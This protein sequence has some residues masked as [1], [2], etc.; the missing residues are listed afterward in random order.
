MG[1]TIYGSLEVQ[2]SCYLDN[3]MHTE[4]GTER[5]VRTRTIS[6][7]TPLRSRGKVYEGCISGTDLLYRNSVQEYNK[8]MIAETPAVTIFNLI[9]VRKHNTRLNCTRQVPVLY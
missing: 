4:A 2:K 5:A 8:E 7:N 3:M 6:K 1:E 9:P